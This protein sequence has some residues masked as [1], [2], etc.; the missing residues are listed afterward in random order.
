MVFSNTRYLKYPMILKT[1]RVR[2]GYW[3][4]FQVRGGYRVPVGHCSG[5]TDC[6]FQKFQLMNWGFLSFVDTPWDAGKPLW[7]RNTSSPTSLTSNHIPHCYINQIQSICEWF[8][9]T[10][11][12]PKSKEL[13]STFHEAF[14]F[15]KCQKIVCKNKWKLP[16][17]I[18]KDERIPVRCNALQNC[19]K[20]I[21]AS[22]PPLTSL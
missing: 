3:K 2:I 10:E 19:Q 9:K 18:N 14:F 4:I 6:S 17:F 22:F 21:R 8:L 13:A 12:P 16:H 15:K 7:H 20:F 5:D 1:N 11:Q